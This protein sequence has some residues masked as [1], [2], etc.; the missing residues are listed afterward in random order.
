MEIWLLR[1]IYN[2][3]S[4]WFIHI[5]RPQSKWNYAIFNY[6]WTSFQ[7]K[8]EQE[9]EHDNTIH[10]FG[11]HKVNVPK[12][13]IFFATIYKN[14]YC[15]RCIKCI[16]YTHSWVSNLKNEFYYIKPIINLLLWKCHCYVTEW[17][18]W[19]FL[20]ARKIKSNKIC[21]HVKFPS[22]ILSLFD[23]L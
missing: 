13:K 21:F 5:I 17:Q 20:L 16:L 9:Q 23:V 19:P 4:F 7:M 15:F 18:N 3:Y 8:E 22:N 6:A 10:Q 11:S 2:K 14:I 1:N 12:V